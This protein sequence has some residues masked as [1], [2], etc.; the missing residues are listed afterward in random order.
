MAQ[1]IS[2]GKSI[3]YTPTSSVTAGDVVVVGDIVGVA[4]RDIAAN[5]LGS[6]AVYGLYAF[7]KASATTFAAGAKVYWNAGTGKATTTNTDKFCGHAV[8][9]AGSGG[10]EVQV[11]L[12]RVN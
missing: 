5:E 7:P 4:A 1:L 6:L 2:S 11:L 3:D 10:L 12:D 8:A 9:A